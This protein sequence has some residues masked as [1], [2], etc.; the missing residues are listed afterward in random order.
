M[1]RVLPSRAVPSQ[2]SAAVFALMACLLATSCG[3]SSAQ[4][5]C[6]SVPAPNVRV[7]VNAPWGEFARLNPGQT[8]A[9]TDA[10]DWTF[11]VSN[12]SVLEQDECGCALPFR[13]SPVR[14]SLL[15]AGSHPAF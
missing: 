8:L 1:M 2:A 3:P 10:A 13:A 5:A 9:L 12:P 6:P 7:S 11:Q 4:K 15:Y 14:S